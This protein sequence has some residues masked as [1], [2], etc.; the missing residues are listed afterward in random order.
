VFPQLP[1]SGEALDMKA[2]PPEA[3]LDRAI[4]L[5]ALIQE[6]YVAPTSPKL[7]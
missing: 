2:I 6:I 1:E 5:D 4:D 7:T 3:G